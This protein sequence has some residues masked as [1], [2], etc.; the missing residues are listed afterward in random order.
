MTGARV[1]EEIIQKKKKLSQEDEG[2]VQYQ[3]CS[4]QAADIS[5][6]STGERE[7]EREIDLGCE[8][9]KHEEKG[10]QN[11]QVLLSLRSIQGRAF[12]SL[13]S[14]LNQNL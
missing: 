14:L 7:D 4:I 2:K 3:C 9:K 13:T 11:S 6:C 1:G 5:T 8:R 12:S 10:R